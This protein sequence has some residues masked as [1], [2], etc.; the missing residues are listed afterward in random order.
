MKLHYLDV[1]DDIISNSTA[2]TQIVDS[3]DTRMRYAE[4]IAVRRI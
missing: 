3:G 4:S 2:T 1:L